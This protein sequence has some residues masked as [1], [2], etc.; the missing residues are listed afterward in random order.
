MALIFYGAGMASSRSPEERCRS[1]CSASGTILQSWAGW[2]CRAI[3]KRPAISG[4]ALIDG[5]GANGALAALFG[6]AIANVL[7]V[8]ALFALLAR[9][10]RRSVLIPKS[11]RNVSLQVW[12]L[13]TAAEPVVVG[14]DSIEPSAAPATVLINNSMDVE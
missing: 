1:R 12:P 9:Q 5:L 3:G 8:G 4:A 10:P 13:A 2:R 6:V 14:V 7:L 11:K